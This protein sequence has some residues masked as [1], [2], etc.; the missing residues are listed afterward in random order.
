MNYIAKIA[1]LLILL[2]TIYSCNLLSAA[3]IS[4]QGQPTKEVPEKLT[5]TTANSKVNIDHS[6][7]DRL[8][9]KYVDN[10]GMVDYKGF[11]KDSEELNAYLN[12]L[13]AKEP[14][15]DW[16]VQELLAYY[17]NIYNAYTVDLIIDNYPVKSIKDIDGPWTKGI[18][19]IGNNK[20]SLGGI[21]N[22]ILRKMNEPRIHFAIN[23]ASISCPKLLNEAFTASKINEQLDKAASAF[24]NSDKNDISADSPKLSSIFDWYKK[25]FV[26]SGQQNVIGYINKFSTT[27]IEP[28]VTIEYKDYNWNLNEQQ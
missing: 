13:S 7:W 8:L 1:T 21:E 19:P 11:K 4:S 27:K 12:M 9:K 14:N 3:G 24:I 17:I 18:V 6:G 16:S 22:G 26:V 25:D 15:D 5:S 28:T 23:C 2:A 10:E 20:L